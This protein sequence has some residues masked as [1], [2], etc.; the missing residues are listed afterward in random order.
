MTIINHLKVDQYANRLL[1]QIY[2]TNLYH[3]MNNIINNTGDG[4]IINTGNENKIENN[5]TLYK[6]DLSRIQSEFE[7]QGIDK[8]DIQ[9]VSKIIAEEQLNTE[10]NSLGEKS[11]GWISKIINKSLNG[12]GKVASGIFA[13]VLATIIKQYYGLD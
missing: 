2:E 10:A 13:N 11:N 1:H 3:Q 7:K 9:E 6:G 5:T 8:E 4:N 12:V